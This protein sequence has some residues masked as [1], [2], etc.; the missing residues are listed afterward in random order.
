MELVVSELHPN[1]LINLNN[2]SQT[3]NLEIFQV[4]NST[5]EIKEGKMSGEKTINE[6]SIELN[7]IN[8]DDSD[9]IDFR[10]YT[11]NSNNKNEIRYLEDEQINFSY[12]FT[13]TKYLL[14]VGF[15]GINVYLKQILNVHNNDG[16]RQ[17]E[18]ILNI[19]NRQY[20]LSS[21]DIYQYYNSGAKTK[22]YDRYGEF[23]LL[24]KNFNV[25]GFGIKV[26]F[27][28][29]CSLTNGIS[30][31]VIE[32]QM[33]TKGYSSFYIGVGGNIALNFI[34]ASFEG[35]V[36]GSIGE[37]NSYI[38]ANSIL[39][40]DKIK[41]IF[42]NRLSSCSV[43]LDIYFSIWI[44]FWKKEYSQTFNLFKGFSVYDY[45]YEYY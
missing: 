33:Y 30:I 9:K 43:S 14:I 45:Y 3:I 13:R 36:T 25:F 23:F 32:S 6:S 22:S 1:I 19:G 11:N 37:G 28:L 42:Y 40:S 21:I 24:E 17:N 39:N 38:Q 16:L 4:S 18:L 12:S 8:P 41:I 15:L 29:Q 26:S 5:I 31:N 10:K 34:V 7:D 27:Y 35:K 2:L 44:L 20:T